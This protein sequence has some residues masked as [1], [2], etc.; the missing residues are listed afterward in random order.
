M[1]T[2]GS[3]SRRKKLMQLMFGRAFVASLLMAF[4]VASLLMA[5]SDLSLGPHVDL[6]PEDTSMIVQE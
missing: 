4:S 5:F 2:L 1:L 6:F 3:G